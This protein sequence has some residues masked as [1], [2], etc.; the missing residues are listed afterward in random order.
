MYERIADRNIGV[1]VERYM[2]FPFWDQRREIVLINT[3]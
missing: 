1:N 3:T 2:R